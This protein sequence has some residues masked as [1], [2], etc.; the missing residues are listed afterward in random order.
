MTTK[1]QFVPKTISASNTT[2]W[3]LLVPFQYSE[4]I[5]GRVQRTPQPNPLTW[6]HT[7]PS[8]E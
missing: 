6:V 1:S 8:S 5:R 3:R 7:A 4:A 2:Y